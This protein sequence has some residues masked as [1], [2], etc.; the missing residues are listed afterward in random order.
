[1]KLR[2]SHASP[3]ARK[4]RVMILE[5][6]LAGR[7]ELLETDTRRDRAALL[8]ENPLGKIPVLITDEGEALYDSPVICEYLDALHNDAPRLPSRGP[9]RFMVLRR[10]A[11]ADGLMDAAV[12]RRMESLR[13]PAERSAGHDLHLRSAIESALD[14]LDREA[15]GFGQFLDLGQ[16]ATACA[17]GYLDFRFAHEPWRAAHPRL[18]AWFENVGVRESMRAT[19]PPA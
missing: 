5:C 6:G 4:A 12:A 13:V 10:Q 9:E 2:H 15:G 19:A 1:M 3:Y 14:A 17:L 7:V 16:I 8:R 18:A 11:L